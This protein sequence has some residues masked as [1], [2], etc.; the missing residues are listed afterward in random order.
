MSVNET[1][2][3]GGEQLLEVRDLRVEW[4]RPDGERINLVR[5][6][7]YTIGAGEVTC[8]VGESGSGKSVTSLAVL[9]LIQQQSDIEVTGQVLLGDTSLLS[10]PESDYRGLRGRDIAM[11]FQEPMSSLDPV[12]TV[13]SQLREAIRRRE[14][15]PRAQ[16]RDRMRELLTTVGI[17]D[18]ARIL[19]QYPHEMSGGMCQRVMI[20]VALA[21][22]PRLLIAD[23][24]TTAI[25]ATLQ[26]QVIALLDHLRRSTGMSVLLVTHDMGVAAEV[27]DRV[28]IMYAGRVVEQGRPA[29]I[30]RAPA[31]P[32]TAGLLASIPRI[33]G[34]R[35]R[36]LPS[37]SG[38][39]PDPARL[40]TGC[41]FHPRC[42]L[43]QQRCREEDPPLLTTDDDRTAAAC[44]RSDEIRKGDVAAWPAIPE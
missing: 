29:Q 33:D 11:V 43:V 6:A 4:K 41:A 13:E 26:V 17:N 15:L 3:A 37:V 9:G 25:D 27:A 40:P 10:L 5:D 14:K 35:R 1:K 34:P 38:S 16:E 2:P 19:R 44:W 42:R 20:A 39:V 8:V 32:Y 18:P 24:P 23:E 31:H 30:F 36:L 21:A 22:R 28:V 12:F 7:T